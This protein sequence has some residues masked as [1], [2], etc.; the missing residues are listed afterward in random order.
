MEILQLRPRLTA[1]RSNYLF[2][3]TTCSRDH[4]CEGPPVRGDYRSRRLPFSRRLP[5][6]GDYFKATTSHC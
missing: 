4:L 5:V 6:R 2:E 3:A 1:V